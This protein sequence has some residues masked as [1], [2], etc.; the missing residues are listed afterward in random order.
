MKL[1]VVYTDQDK[2]KELVLYIAKKC[3]LDPTFGATKLNKVLFYSDFYSFL[4]SGKSITGAKYQHLIHGPAPRP[5]IPVKAELIKNKDAVEVS[6]NYPSGVQKRLVAISPPKLGLFSAD[7][8]AL[9]DQIIEWLWE[10]RADEVSNLS[11]LEIGW[12]I[13]SL[14]EDIPYETVLISDR[15]PSRDDIAWAKSKK[16]S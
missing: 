13:T 6:R 2:F 10:K 15:Q 11:H 12:Q 8:I 7:E 16:V 9:V 1:Q 3:E 14:G 5:L 4:V